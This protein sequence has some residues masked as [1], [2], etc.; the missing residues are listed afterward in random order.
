MQQ[1]L[2]AVND[3]FG[4]FVGFSNFLWSFPTQF[5]FWR[6]I[7]ILGQFTMPIILLFS[8]GIIF[9]LRSKFVQIRFFKKG[10]HI[11]MERKTAE[12]GISPFA[13]FM[14]SAAMRIGSG[15]IVGV[16][17]AI[18]IGGPGALFW[19]WVSAFLGM[20]TSF[21][22]A[23]LSQIFKERKGDE[24]VGGLT[25]YAE[26]LYHN[27]RWVGVAIGIGFFFYRVLSTPV[28]TFHMYTAVGK[29]IT[30]LTGHPAERTSPLYYALAVFIVISL[31]IV[32]FGGIKRVT[33]LTDKMVPFMA[34]GYSALVIFIVVINITKLPGFFVAVFRGAF[35]PDAIFGGMFGVALI[36]GIKR[37][38]LSNEAGQ[39][40]TTMAAATADNDHP[41][42][43]GLIQ[44]I[45]V[46]LDTFVI[47]TMTGFMVTMGAIWYNPAYDWNSISKSLI[48]V[49]AQSVAVLVPGTAFD[50]L[51]IIVVCLAYSFF[52]FTTLLGG[53]VF[54][55]ISASKISMSPKM[56]WFVR[57]M[58]VCV[59]VPVGCLSV[60]AGLEL[61]NMWGLSDL[62]NV[63]ATFV[64]VPTN[65]Y[66]GRIAMAA[67]KDYIDTNGAPFCSERIGIKTDIWTKEFAE[68][69]AKRR[70]EMSAKD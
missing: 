59:M 36:Q 20:A 57:I 65:L 68:A 50:N 48:D 6:A 61:G 67:L 29:M 11:L 53:I 41:C 19:M 15:N 38:L 2:K 58:M 35:R 22:E 54:C 70:L 23:T 30:T 9:T 42:E 7:P 27:R 55:E 69:R 10:V 17:G 60:L 16:T 52:A 62:V 37:G 24:Y 56:T 12:I 3:F 21:V 34:I 1:V 43:Q 66:G 26:K 4:I 63:L 5:S 47:C 51:A 25:H 46:F 40:T 49:F 44:A 28:L 45:A 32:V 31:A 39:G 8:A 13:S 33:K 18:A 14:L 64:N